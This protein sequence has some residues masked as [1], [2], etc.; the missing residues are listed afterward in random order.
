MSANGDELDTTGDERAYRDSRPF[1]SIGDV[2]LKY[3]QPNVTV[4]TSARFATHEVIGNV[5]VRQKLGEDPDE[6]SIEGIC[7]KEEANQIDGL[8]N[9][10]TVDVVSNRWSGRAQVASTNTRP[11]A[12]GGGKDIDDEWLHRFTVELVGVREDAF[13]F[14]FDYGRFLL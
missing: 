8:K 4:N 10:E 13:E 11:V 1:V 6:I 9:Q 12:D 2:E 5:T 14:D 3:E 7:T